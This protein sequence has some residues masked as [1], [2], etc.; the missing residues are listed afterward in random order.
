MMFLYCF[1]FFSY[2]V[3]TPDD[4]IYLLIYKMFLSFI[5]A[6]KILQLSPEGGRI[7]DKWVV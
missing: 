6:H 3:C 1:E 4:V 5:L 2:F 7:L